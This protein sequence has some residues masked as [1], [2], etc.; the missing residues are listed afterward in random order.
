MSHS[1]LARWSSRR[2]DG[3]AN[4]RWRSLH[5]LRLFAAGIF[6]RFPH[7][8]LVLGHMGETIPYMLKRQEAATGR[9]THLTRPL[10]E[11]WRSN[12]WVT[13][14]GM[15][16]T[17]PLTVLLSVCPSDHVMMSIDYP[18]SATEK[19]RAFVEEIE[20]QGLLTGEALKAFS[21]GNA[22]KL[23]RL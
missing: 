10:S 5:F 1:V 3:R 9:W 7:L 23:L 11:V 14:S 12:V 18:F 6:D 21:S 13:T 4:R 19:G 17:A 15:F 20:K 2:K 22:A 8:K 16:D